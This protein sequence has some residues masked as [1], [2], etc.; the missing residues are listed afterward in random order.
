M[1]SNILLD[2]ATNGA[3]IGI[4]YGLAAVGAG[5]AA[6][7]AGIGIGRI[8]GSALESIARQPEVA[9]DIRANMILAA[10][11]VEGAAFFAMVIG[12]LAI[13]TK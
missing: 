10:A 1:L 6:V 12:L 2:A 11:L 5:L 7:G 9:G 8:G 13:L 4:G 3:N